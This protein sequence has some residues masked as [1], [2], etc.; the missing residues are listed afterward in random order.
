MMWD[1]VGQPRI[2]ES[3]SGGWLP[4]GDSPHPGRL[5]IHNWDFL[6]NLHH[7]HSAFVQ[8]HLLYVILAVPRTHCGTDSTQRPLLTWWPAW[9]AS[10]SC[11]RS[12]WRL[13][14]SPAGSW[15]SPAGRSR[16][17]RGAEWSTWTNL[18]HFPQILS[19][20]TRVTSGSISGWRLPRGWVWWGPPPHC[21]P[22]QRHWGWQTC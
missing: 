21:R 9:E 4:P 6:G 12:R 17:H 15:Q 11:S 2:T 7:L 14:P 8:Q 13:P 20:G 5:N 16:R 18:G 10:C 19:P 1:W 3:W 22:W